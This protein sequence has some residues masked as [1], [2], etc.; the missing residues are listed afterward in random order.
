MK[1]ISVTIGSLRTSKL[2]SIGLWVSLITL[3]I[4]F[5]ILGRALDHILSLR[6][7]D[8]HQETKKLVDQEWL[9]EYRIEIDLYEITTCCLYGSKINLG[10]IKMSQSIMEGLIDEFKEN[11]AKIVPI[12]LNSSP[13]NRTN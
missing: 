8:P 1:P 12:S 2:M 7:Y 10:I 4:R 3:E 11:A 9:Q 5:W 13:C 6:W